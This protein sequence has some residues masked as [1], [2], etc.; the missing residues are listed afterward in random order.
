MK[1]VIGAGVVACALTAAASAQESL[2]VDVSGIESF[3]TLGSVENTVLTFELLPNATVVGLEWDVVLQANGGS[4]LSEM[5]I[6]FGSTAVV[7]APSDTN[8]PGGNLPEANSGSANLVDL[9]LA[10]DVAGDG[11]LRMEFFESF[12]DTGVVPN[13]V[14]V[15]GTIT[16]QYVPAPAGLALLGAAGLAGSRRRR[17]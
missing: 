16:V 1:S 7:F 5:T 6:A 8:S 12:Y 11:I 14:W 3:N 4:W 15:S 13:G 2:V 10:F 9:G 17:G